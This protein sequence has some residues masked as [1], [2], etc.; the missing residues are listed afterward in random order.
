MNSEFLGLLTA[1][2]QRGV[3]P[4]NL[5]GSIHLYELETRITRYC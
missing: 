2:A 3:V 1:D 5:A 4:G